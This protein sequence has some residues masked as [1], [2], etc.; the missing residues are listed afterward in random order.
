M[1]E[2]LFLPNT[3]RVKGQYKMVKIWFSITH[4]K[5]Q[6]LK[7]SSLLLIKKTFL[8]KN[9]IFDAFPHGVPPNRDWY[10]NE[11]ELVTLVFEVIA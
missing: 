11:L 9:I 5:V 7:V 3:K 8:T 1:Y 10:L 6:L 4:K 2:R